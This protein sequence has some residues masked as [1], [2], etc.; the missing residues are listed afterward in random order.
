M[1]LLSSSLILCLWTEEPTPDSTDGRVDRIEEMHLPTWDETRRRSPNFW[2][3]PQLV[4]SFPRR[5]TVLSSF[6]EETLRLCLG[7]NREDA[8]I[9]TCNLACNEVHPCFRAIVL[10]ACSSLSQLGAE[11]VRR[12]HACWWSDSD[13]QFSLGTCSVTS[14]KK[15]RAPGK[16]LYVV[17]RN[18]F[19]LLLNCSAWPCLGPA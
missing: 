5:T 17:A 8:S 3:S 4:S 11:S 7:A 10:A 15:Y 6:P 14:V 2:C 12:C 19:L 9:H 18:L 16:C 13:R 1:P